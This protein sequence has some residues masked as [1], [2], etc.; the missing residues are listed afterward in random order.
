MPGISDASGPAAVRTVICAGRRRSL[1]DGSE[2][3]RG[4]ELLWFLVSRDLKVAYQQTVLGMGWALLQPLLATALFTWV[5]G[6]LV[7]MPS[8]GLP[9]APFA[10]AGMLPWLYFSSAVTASA[11]SLT[12]N[13]ALVSKVY[14]PRLFLP[15]VPA[16]A[17]LV[18]FGVGLLALLALALWSGLRPG[19]GILW[20]PLPLAL[21]ALSAAGLG[22]AA[23]ALAA[24]YRDVRL[25][26]PFLLQL[27][28]F[29]APVAWP[30]SLLPPAWRP[31]YAL[32]PMAGAI[33]GLRAAVL[34]APLP[35]DLLLPGTASALALAFAGAVLFARREQEFAD[36]A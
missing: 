1:P 36:V 29:A 9:Y 25:A 5:F 21:A 12:S 24:R 8:D 28:L 18:D 20:L 26:L 33:E 31:L 32:F 4:R 6:G 30:S 13:A 3:W 34:G 16:L 14:L 7:R 19:A 35:W 27:L 2:L 11:G 22:C 23:A 15:L 17:R 10:C